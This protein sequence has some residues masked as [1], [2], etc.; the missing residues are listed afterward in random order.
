MTLILKEAR[1]KDCWKQ[2]YKREYK[3]TLDKVSFIDG[4]LYDSLELV[5]KKGLT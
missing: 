4:N 1:F 2:V 3:L 5:L